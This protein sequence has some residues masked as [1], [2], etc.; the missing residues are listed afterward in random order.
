VSL[1][2]SLSTT[3][4]AL[5]AQRAGLA[6]TGQNLANLNT[7]G[8]VRRR[9]DLAEGDPSIGGVDV[10]GVRA[11]RDR[12]LEAR[13]RQELPAESRDTAIADSLSIVEAILGAPGEALDARL[14]AFFDSFHSLA[15]D[16]SSSVLRDSVVLQ[17]RTLADAFNDLAARLDE[18]RRAADAGIRAGVDEINSLTTRIAS[19]NAA[20]TGANGA[21]VE[22]LVDEQTLALKRLAELADVS[23][24]YRPD[25]AFDVAIGNGRAL[26]IGNT[27]VDLVTDTNPAGF[28]VITVDGVD[29]TAQINRGQ[30]AGLLEVRDTY[31]P[32]YQTRLDDLAFGVAQEVNALHQTGTDLNGGTGNDFFSPLGTAVGAAAALTMDAGILADS[33]LVAA[34]QTGAIGDN[35]IAKAIADL[36]DARV[37]GGSATF[38]ESWGQ[39]MYRVGTDVL[40]ARS[41]AKA[42]HDVVTQVGNLLEQIEGVSMDEEAAILMRFQR[43]YE[44]NAKYFSTID[45]VLDTL[46]NMVGTF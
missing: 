18:T 1:L 39:L 8:Y 42:R 11:T 23:V 13:L 25:G 46:M 21:D 24:I 6:V 27:Q 4:R 37:M 3:A 38:S 31:V 40:T 45:Q 32:E 29:I 28:A 2:V 26:V 22:A 16:P 19:L 15:L 5:E 33:D 14:T 30:I 7:D 20:I 41:Q 35:G 34:S 43:G 17:G 10:V 9:I 12:L 36:R 44:A